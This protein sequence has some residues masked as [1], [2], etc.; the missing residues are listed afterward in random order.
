V[1]LLGAAI[2]AR[3]F[4]GRQHSAPV[5]AEIPAA[6][7]SPT[8]TLPIP[9]PQSVAKDEIGR[10]AD[11]ADDEHRRQ[12]QST[13]RTANTLVRVREAHVG[14]ETVK[15]SFR[16]SFD[17]PRVDPNAFVDDGKSGGFFT[18]LAAEAAAGS[19]GA[20]RHRYEALQICRHVP[21]TP[22]DQEAQRKTIRDAFAASGGGDSGNTLEQNLALA[23]LHYDR[24]AGVNESM[25][26]EAQGYLREAADREDANAGL[27]YAAAI[28]KDQPDEARQRLEVLWQQG[29]VT[30]LGGLAL[31]GRDPLAYEI[32]F[33]AQHIAQFDPPESPN[34]AKLIELVGA[35]QNK[36]RN[37]TSPSEY[38]EAAKKAA[39]LL[40]NP[41][42]C[43]NP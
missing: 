24:C 31:V 25:F 16:S 32:A 22:K 33:N 4:Y 38:N 15:L 9:V 35:Q 12:G 41:A 2:A 40:R 42:C 11:K 13:S 3:Y 19:D 26:T 20:A 6:A 8:P 27:E 5:T 37:E 23:Q 43:L 14:D 18:P 30:A 39:A 28:L 36:L 7:A 29:H 1:L 17:R 10:T 34:A 21:L